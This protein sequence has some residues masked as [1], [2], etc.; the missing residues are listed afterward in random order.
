MRLKGDPL[1]A[2]VIFRSPQGQG[3]LRRSRA[4]SVYDLEPGEGMWLETMSSN[5][6]SEARANVLL[7]RLDIFTL[8]QRAGWLGRS[9]HVRRGMNS[10]RSELEEG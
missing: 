3:V 5:S 10:E 7:Q 8:T 2:Y 6:R 4:G 9:L 1:L